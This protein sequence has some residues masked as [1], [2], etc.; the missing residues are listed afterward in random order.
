MRKTMRSVH[1]NP[2]FCLVLA[3]LTGCARVGWLNCHPYRL[4]TQ[5]W[6]R[7]RDLKVGEY[8]SEKR[9]VSVERR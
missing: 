7:F 2:G 3:S 6:R 9:P 1:E 8:L 4:E 5:V